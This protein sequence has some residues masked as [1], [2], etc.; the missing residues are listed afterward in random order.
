MD[1]RVSLPAI[2][3]EG[4]NVYV[5]YRQ[6]TINVVVSR[7]R[8]KTWT[9]PI[10]IAP[11]L[12]VTSAPAIAQV[13]S[14]IILVFPARI[15]ANEVTPYQLHYA[16]SMDQ[17]NTWSQPRRITSSQ[18]DTYSPRL[19]V[20]GNTAHLLWLE[21]PTEGLA[22]IGRGGRITDTSPESMFSMNVQVTGPSKDI[23]SIFFHSVFN[24]Q[25]SSFS[26]P[27]RVG[28]V[29][30]PVLPHIFN[31]Y[32]PFTGGLFVAAN[33][34]TQIKLFRST[35]QGNTW[36]P[37]FRDTDL[38]NSTQVVDLHMID[39]E[40]VSVWTRREPYREIPV[41]FKQG[42]NA[43]S[44]QL[45]SSISFRSLP[46][47]AYSDGVH[48]VAW[49]GGFRKTARIA[50]MRTDE[51]RQLPVDSAYQ[52]GY[53]DSFGDFARR[54]RI[55]F[56]PMTAWSIPTVLASSGPPFKRICRQPSSHHRMGV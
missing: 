55:I 54:V 53:C 31:I 37:H 18:Q 50:Y 6:K 32:G 2:A 34:N 9:Q 1:N 23:R 40:F 38:F 33:E 42:R 17:G 39:N 14:K 22:S 35:D 16:E 46:R 8:G 28:E 26:D 41:M 36:E 43:Q 29:K 44:I 11:N 51:I 3:A 13:G 49:G 47:F 4:D 24:P 15:S 56:H 48:H 52:S 19:L 30:A 20:T 12:A 5:A 25:N 10:S 45:S 21:T 27:G 7:D